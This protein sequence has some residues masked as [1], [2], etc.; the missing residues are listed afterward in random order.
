MVMIEVQRTDVFID[1]FDGLRDERA[2]A[3]IATRI[4]RLSLGNP[5]DWKS[6]GGGVS[7]MRIAYGPGYRLYSTRQGETVVILLCGGNKSSQRR[8]IETA[9]TL[10]REIRG[11]K[12]SN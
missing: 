10:L 9:K 12:W 3:A 6:V 2:K 4:D 1:W 11:I 7:E 8:D 5:G